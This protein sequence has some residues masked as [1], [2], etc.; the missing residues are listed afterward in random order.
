MASLLLHLLGSPVM[1]PQAAIDIVERFEGLRLR[2]YKCP[3]GIWTC[4]VGHTGPDVD[5]GLVVS[6]DVAEEWLRVDLEHAAKT[7]DR[8]VATTLNSNER[9]ALISFVF[10][11]GSGAFTSSTL[12]KVLNMGDRVGAANQFLRWDK[13]GGKV[14][15][16]LT[17]RRKAERALFLTEV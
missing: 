1:I 5:E 3:A 15:P 11:L 16:G 12:L 6:E 10:N 13:A 4:G 2:A 9:S 7:V 17:K 8:A 14:L